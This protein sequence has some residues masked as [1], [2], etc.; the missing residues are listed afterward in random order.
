MKTQNFVT[1]FALIIL[2]AAT[3]FAKVWTVD[4]KSDA[5]ADF[6]EIQ[7]AHDAAMAGDT[8]YVYSS[9]SNY[10]K[11]VTVTKKLYLIGTG[12][13]LTE[14]PNTQADPR[15]AFCKGFI[16]NSGSDGSL[17]TGF[18][19]WDGYDDVKINA[20]NIII[21]RN[22]VVG[23]AGFVITPDHSNIIITGNYISNTTTSGSN[24]VIDIAANCNNIQI[25]NNYLN[26]NTQ[27][28]IRSESSSAIEVWN[29]VIGG[30][31]EIHNSLFYNNIMMS[32]DFSG[33]N[34]ASD[35]NHNIG[36]ANQFG[37]DNGNQANISMNAVFLL[38]GST[39]GHWQL[40][41]GSPAIGAGLS[42]EDTGMFGGTTPYILSGLPAIPTIYFFVAPSSASGTQGLQVQ[43]K[44][45]SNN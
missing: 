34:S 11:T 7:A 33:T 2:F 12:Y 28:A 41:S 6:T 18:K 22:M 25:N 9:G 36:D 14:N 38:S 27:Y 26:S 35:I 42:G 5:V 30:D 32:G 8:I 21:K 44:A 3:A 10:Y 29:N 19:I 40:K 1:I 45:K 13:F 15:A 4:N 17:L 37:T 24:R 39:D 23:S 43:I 16:F 20:D 31:V